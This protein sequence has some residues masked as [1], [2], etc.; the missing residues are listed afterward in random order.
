MLFILTHF[1]LMLL[2]LPQTGLSPLAPGQWKLFGL[3]NAGFAVFH[4][5]LRPV[6]L[7]ASMTTV[8]PWMDRLVARLEQWRLSRGWAVATVAVATNVVGTLVLMTTGVW[9]AAT[10]SQ[11]PLFV[12]VA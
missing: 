5:A 11:V 4:N 2:F 12:G 3:V 8:G 10:A 1:P 7:A 6:Y 9:V